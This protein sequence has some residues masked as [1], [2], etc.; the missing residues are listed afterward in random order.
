M[1]RHHPDENLLL[2]Y[3]SGSLARGPS[4]VVAAH[5][6]MCADCRSQLSTLNN[7]G[8]SLLNG[9]PAQPLQANAFERLMERI[10]QIPEKIIHKS[11][12]TPTP[13][14]VGRE[15]AMDHL[16]KVLNKLLASNPNRRWKT[17]TRNLQMCRLKSGQ[18]DYEVAFHCLRSGSGLPKHDHRGQEFALVLHGSF[19]DHNGIYGRGDFVLREPGQVHRPIATQDMDCLCFSAVAAPV[20]LTGIRGLFLNP[21]IPFRPG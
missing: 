3:A 7:L 6:Q 13:V 1:I 21:L 14:P 19:S 4:L 16:P 10:S 12:D 18:R 15:P 2:E 20:S 8:G 17:L 5:V 11:E 9:S